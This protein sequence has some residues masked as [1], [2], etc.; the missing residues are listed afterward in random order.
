MK[1]AL[2]IVLES[3]GTVQ[4]SFGTALTFGLENA[5]GDIAAAAKVAAIWEDPVAENAQLAFMTETGG[6]VNTGMTL[7][8]AG[9]LGVGT[10]TPNT[11]LDLAG[12]LTM[13]LAAQP[14]SPASMGVIYFDQA[15]EKFKI[16]E[17]GAGW[18][19]LVPAG[20]PVGGSGTQNYIAKF[21]ASGKSL[22]DSAIYGNG[23][24]IGIGT[25][26]PAAR[27]DVSSTTG[28]TI[29]IRVG[30][31]GQDLG[32]V[33]N[34]IAADIYSSSGSMS[35]EDSLVAVNA[36]ILV[37]GGSPGGAVGVRSMVQ[38]AGGTVGTAAGLVIDQFVNSGTITETYGVK[39]AN[40]T[41]GTQTSPPYAVYSSDP[42]ARTYLAGSLG[43]GT[44]NPM[45][46]VSTFK[47]EGALLLGTVYASASSTTVTGDTTTFQDDFGVWDI[48]RIDDEARYIASIVSDTEL[49]VR[50]PWG[51][52]H[53]PAGNYSRT[54]GAPSVAAELMG[55]H[56]FGPEIA[57]MK[58]RDADDNGSPDAIASGDILGM[59]TMSGHDGGG[60]G[61][62]ALIM[63]FATENWSSGANG[64]RMAFLTT[65]IGQANPLERMIIAE[66]G[67][68]G[69]GT[70]VPNSALDINGGLT[71]QMAS[72]P[73]TPGTTGVVYFDGTKFKVNENNTGWVDLIPAGG[74]I[75]G[76]GTQNFLPKFSDAGGQTLGDSI[77]FD[78][79]ANIGIGTITPAGLFHVQG[80]DSTSDVAIFTPGAGG[81]MRVGIGTASPMAQLDVAGYVRLD[82]T[83]LN[84]DAANN[85]V[86][87]GLGAP[88]T[89]L[90][91]QGA[92]ATTDVATFM[93]GAGGDMRVGVGTTLPGSLVE[94]Q[95][96][97]DSN[98][99]AM[100]VAID[101][102]DV[103]PATTDAAAAFQ[104]QI[105]SDSS[106][107][108]DRY[109]AGSFAGVLT[110]GASVGG[111]GSVRTDIRHQG[112]GT[113]GSAVAFY[114]DG[115]YNEGGGTITDTY[116][117]KIENLTGGNQTNAP[118]AIHSEDPNARTYLAGNVGVGAA[119]TDP[120]FEIDAPPPRAGR[121]AG[122]AR[123]R[124]GR[125][126]LQLVAGQAHALPA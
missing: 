79:G 43:V 75:G 120:G 38:N 112:T 49:T 86:G 96:T 104:A 11:R 42:N 84:V 34:A 126:L 4:A 74:P 25:I 29:G 64:G 73:L 114:V 15:E 124:D 55:T 85:H 22:V 61:T 59:V 89:V 1:D 33:D 47:R 113:A 19:D 16:N 102:H 21:D 51:A 70:T 44:A 125:P 2:A 30:V 66:T 106:A 17:S 32:G 98:T 50:S 23:T 56:N 88:A 58:S 14:S 39:I 100:S 117:L 48:I 62:G 5:T 78:D 101:F 92:D 99:P 63:A 18:V 97:P 121:A 28:N 110:G 77:V 122:P 67:N 8:S 72:A 107:T 20:G 108:E 105:T 82:G 91:V 80:A 57:L 37:T 9:D 93:P 26:T 76:G 115:F 40:L 45:G 119:A 103:T 7:T 111:F 13:Q 6:S 3:T 10:D 83:T 95:G 54:S 116:G 60:Y 81:S 65:P 118:Y 69:I 87:I 31:L 68:V 109:I 12:G 24:N 27:L 52:D 35:T 41:A 71:M 53:T 46:Q 123:R 94:V 36:G 90:H